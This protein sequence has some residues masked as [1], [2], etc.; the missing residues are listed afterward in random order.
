MSSRLRPLI[1]ATALLAA[2]GT[3]PSGSEI[4]TSDTETPDGQ[5]G[6]DAGDAVTT[7]AGDPDIAVDASPP[8]STPEDGGPDL[9]SQSDGDGSDVADLD[10]DADVSDVSPETC[11]PGGSAG[12]LTRDTLQG[13]LVGESVDGAIRFLGVPYATPPVGELRWRAAEGPA[14]YDEGVLA[15]VDWPAPCPQLSQ[16]GAFVGRE[17]CLY[18]NVWEPT[19]PL[20]EGPRPLLVFIHGGGNVQGAISTTAVGDIRIYDGALMAEQ[21]GAVVV[22]IA[23]RLGV[24]G[25]LARRPETLADGKGGE[26]NLG[27]LDQITALRWVRDNAAAFG[28]D[29]EN[30]TIFGQSAG[31]RNVAVLA[32]SPTARGL[33]RAAIIQSGAATVPAA[34]LV[35]AET[36]DFLATF[37]DCDGD[38]DCLRAL[39]A[40][41]LMLEYPLQASTTASSGNAQPMVDGIHLLDQPERVYRN[42][43]AVVDAIIVGATDDET[44]RG[45][46]DV[47][48]EAAVEATVRATY[49]VF[50]DQ[51]LDEYLFSEFSSPAEMYVQLSSDARFVCNARRIA[52][53][54]SE[55]GVPVWH[56]HFEQALRGRGASDGSWHGLDLL[57]LYGQLSIAGYRPGADEVELGRTMRLHWGNLAFDGS[58]DGSDGW[59]Q[60]TP[61]TRQ[62][63]VYVAGDTR[64]AEGIRAARCDFWD[65]LYDTLIEP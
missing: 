53:A 65:E 42:G 21:T 40:E 22:T 51:I 24:L 1:V 9:D 16:E 32:A 8:D 36:D 23:Y 26:P 2:C 12:P 41:E 54:A 5:G 11:S 61:E 13:R 55:G 19:A 4:D 50:A 38:L 6:G 14:C 7:D 44:S 3:D 30:I 25:W 29:P 56:Y 58:P 45:V 46:P 49:T 37:A 62:S 33:V 10:A 52:A 48:T 20:A 28:A 64:V 47:L 31:A 27:L 63:L 15:A 17:D 57:Y 60:W 43:D 34:D 39:P 18:L 35:Y 59:P